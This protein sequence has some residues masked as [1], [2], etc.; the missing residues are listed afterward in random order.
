MQDMWQKEERWINLRTIEA[1]QSGELTVHRISSRHVRFKERYNGR[2]L[3]ARGA[4]GPSDRDPTA[5]SK[6]FL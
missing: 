5:R 4:F 6:A 2:D 1:R 3:I